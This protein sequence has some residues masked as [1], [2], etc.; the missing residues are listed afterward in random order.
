MVAFQ[1]WHTGK[2][3]LF[4]IICAIACVPLW[5]LPGIGYRAVMDLMGD[6]LLNE[7]YILPEPVASVVFAV[8]WAVFLVVAA[9]P[10]V[11]TWK[12]FSARERKPPYS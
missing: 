9:T 1:N 12:W 10:F 6:Y 4:W 7:M 2:L 11:V 5:F 3:V 8:L